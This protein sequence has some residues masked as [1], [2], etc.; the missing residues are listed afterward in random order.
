MASEAFDYIVVGGGSA[1][2]V[3]A[4]RLSEDGASRVL[5][6][7]AGGSDRDWRIQMPLGVGELLN[8]G[9]H[10]WNYMTEP[11]AGLAG[12]QIA[13]PRGKV[14]GGSSSINGMVYTR[15][16]ALDYEGWVKDHGCAGWGYADV[17][18][19]FRRAETSVRGANPWRGGEGPLRTSV[20]DLSRNPLNARFM[21]AGRQAGYP[22]TE[23]SNAR[24]FEGFGPNEYTIHKGERWSAYKGYLRNNLGRANLKVLSGRLA[25]KVEFAGKRATGVTVT[26]NGGREFY[27]ARR[28]VILCGGAI[29]SPQLLMLSGIGPGRDLQDLGIEV[30]ADLA[31]VGQNLQDHP[32]LTVQYWCKQPVTLYSLTRGLG[33]WL[34]GLRWFLS[35]SGPAAS[36]QFEAAAYIR[37]AA[38]IPYPNLKL[39]LLPLAFMPSSLEPRPGHAFQVHMTLQRAKSRGEIRLKSLDPG[40]APSLRFNYLAEPQDLADFRAAVRLT[41]EIIAQPAMADFTG[42][43]I[44]P[45]VDISSD[46]ELD[47]WIRQEVTTA[48]HPSGTCRMGPASDPRTVLDTEL[49]VKG[50]EGLRVVD[51]SIMPLVISSNINAPT[52]MIAEK[53]A[54]MIRGRPAL[55][56]EG[57]AYWVNP[58]WINKQ[59]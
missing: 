5:L 10:N 34:T 20:P 53:A 3:L 4:A 59:R 24:Q 57:A 16:H 22:V 14:L 50:V 46:Q 39:E 56:D 30:I 17:L 12:R 2:C 48:Y 40:A 54:D 38:G 7:E 36:N 52:I 47:C 32:D 11:E 43:E 41:R 55:R 25:E 45:G 26:A 13:H 8:S 27:G 37:T 58:D 42:A 44:Q 31:G 51:A 35:R 9:A 1:G 23:D 19:Y 49:K 6:I 15:G 33:K 29:N 18:P 21:E 28:E